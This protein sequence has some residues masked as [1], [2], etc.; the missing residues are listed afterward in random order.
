M[1][2][3]AAIADKTLTVKSDETVEDILKKMKKAKTEYA[4][5]LDQ[6]GVLIGLT[7]YSILMKNILPV[8]VSLGEE[9]Q[10][11]VNLSAAPG[12]AKRLK[13]SMLL[14]AETF[15]ERKN[16]PIVYPDTP[17]WEGVKLIA[18]TGLPVTVI[19]PETQKYIGFIT[20]SSMLAELQRLQ[21][22]S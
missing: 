4:P 13:N 10:V 3:H 5:V 22:S 2:C 21:E 6:D 7:S 11:D 12:I 17:I 19:D 8:S 9:A 18:Q 16:F 1:P 15:M 20:Q 14:T